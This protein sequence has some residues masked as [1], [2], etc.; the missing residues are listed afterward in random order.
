MKTQAERIQQIAQRS[1]R[2][3]RKE[4]LWVRD[5]W[6]E[7]EI[8]EVPVDLLVLNIDNR[9]F[10]AER[11]W[12]EDK[13]GSFLDPENSPDHERSIESLLLETAHRLDIDGMQI[14]GTPSD[15]Y[16]A[17]RA[18]WQRRRQESP[19]WIRPDGTVRNGNRRLAMIKRL[20][21]EGGD[22]GL[23]WVDAVIL[24]VDDI[25]EAA[26]LEMEQREQLTENFKVRYNDINYL[27]ALR[28]AAVNRDIDWHDRES[29]EQVAGELQ[30]MVEKSRGEVLRDLFAIK[31]MDLFLLD[32]GQPEQYHRLLRTLERFRDIGRTMMR[33]EVDYPLEVDRVLQVLFGAIRSGVPHEDI[34][35]IRRM[36]RQDRE[37]FDQ[38]AD[39][40]RDHEAREIPPEG[41]QL[42]NPVAI[43]SSENGDEDDE[44]D[45]GVDDT[46]GPEVSGYPKR[47]VATSIKVA[48]DA[49]DAS[50]QDITQAVREVRNRLDN[51]SRDRRLAIAL[52]EEDSR[53]VVLA[54]IRAIIAL[55]D[56][57]RG[58][59]SDLT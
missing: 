37:R 42:T 48:I 57:W 1:T 35:S 15:D 50:T 14:T 36:F 31:Y 45:D 51:L 41:P 18:D 59:V 11:M 39:E 54:E 24:A 2:T 55:V 6:R 12:A 52:G 28:E 5:A 44:D 34:R 4:R 25:D 27:L 29:M 10:R 7:F 21:R 58:L 32:A 49:F 3:A 53:E 30:G 56:E 38:L 47:P 26:L 22:I 13:L 40:I 9:R 8:F 46:E 17:L 23:Q 43:P 33:V 20:Q 19:L 16:L